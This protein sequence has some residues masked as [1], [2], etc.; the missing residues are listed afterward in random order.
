MPFCIGVGLVILSIFIYGAKPEQLAEWAG[1]LRGLV[2]MSKPAEYA[3][4]AQMEPVH[5]D[6]EAAG[7]ADE[8][9]AGAADA[10]PPPATPTTAAS[11][12]AAPL[13]DKKF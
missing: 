7:P 12:P 4:V 10:K 8:D 13:S 1:A 5:A 11:T 2:G 9:G 3:L 6:E